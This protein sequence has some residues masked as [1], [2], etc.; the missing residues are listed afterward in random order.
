MLQFSVLGLEEEVEEEE[1]DA[2]LKSREPYSQKDGSLALSPGEHE[3]ALARRLVPHI[4]RYY[5]SCLRII[6]VTCLF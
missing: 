6:S 3:H 4:D 1:E 2:S 5:F